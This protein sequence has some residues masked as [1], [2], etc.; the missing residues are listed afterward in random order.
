MNS[1]AKKAFLIV[2]GILLIDQVSKYLVKTNMI[3]GEDYHVIGDWFR[4]HF[5]ENNGMA[6]GLEFG[7]EKGKFFLTLFRILAV[8]AIIWFLNDLIK[9]KEHP[10]LIACV[11]MILAG[12]IGNIIDSVFYGVIFTDSHYQ[13]ASMF[14]EGGGYAGW[15]QG[16]VV[17]ML[18]FPLID[19][20]L[21]EW[22]P[23]WGG[24]HFIFFRPVFNI[25]DSSITTG[26]FTILIFQKRFFKKKT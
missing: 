7:G 13:V 11:A 20:R 26:V 1:Q 25:A 3:L 23:I 14:P 19:T 24:R 9:K 17:D 2:F 6:F 21:P 10:G 16:K 22:A 5:V 8:G 4:L 15:F 18:Y 12:A